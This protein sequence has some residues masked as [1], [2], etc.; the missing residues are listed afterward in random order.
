MILA[1]IHYKLSH[2]QAKFPRILSQNG[3][4]TLKVKVN[5][6][7]FQAQAMTIPLIYK[8]EPKS[9]LIPLCQFCNMLTQYVNIAKPAK[10]SHTFYD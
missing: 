4:M 8:Q 5:D 9:S 7:H 3:Q 2:G 1:Q 10:R 6:L